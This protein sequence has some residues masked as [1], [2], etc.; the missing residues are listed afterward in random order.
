MDFGRRCEYVDGGE[1]FAGISAASFD[2]D[3]NSDH[4]MSCMS[5]VVIREAGV[6]TY[7]GDTEWCIGFIEAA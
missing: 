4:V 6:T 2:C 5:R 3:A 1:L 7:V